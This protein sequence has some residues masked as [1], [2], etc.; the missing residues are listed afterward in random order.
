MPIRVKSS[1]QYP[2]QVKDRFLGEVGRGRRDKTPALCMEA[3]FHPLAQGL[4]SF[5]RE[6]AFHTGDETCVTD[7][8]F[9]HYS[10]ADHPSLHVLCSYG[11]T[12]CKHFLICPH[13]SLVHYLE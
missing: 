6:V 13:S 7:L 9:L 3:A 12:L 11:F 10:L 8:F 2:V 1:T 5:P 4:S